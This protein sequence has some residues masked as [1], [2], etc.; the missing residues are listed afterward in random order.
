[1]EMFFIILFL[2]VI[3]I[4]LVWRFFVFHKPRN[5]DSLFPDKLTPIA[6][7]GG[8]SIAP[9][10]TMAAFR[11]SAGLGVSFELDTMFSKDGELVVIHDETL[12]RTTDGFGRVSDMTA[13]E[14]AALDAG[15]H[16]SERYRS[17]GVSKLSDVLS[18]FGGKRAIIIEVKCKEGFC[19]PKRLAKALVALLGEKGMEDNVLIAS[20]NSLLL[21]EVRKLNPSIMRGQIY[22][23]FKRDDLESY[24]RFLSKNLLLNR[25]SK[26][27]ALM[28]KH[29][30]VDEGY[31][32]RMHGRGYK[33]FPWTVDD[34]DE[35][36]RLIALGVDGIITNDP[37]ALNE[38]LS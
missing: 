13:A 23:D 35:M 12:E 8:S 30:L 14:L 29:V 22:S 17:E 20:F 25:F 16:F 2:I 26:P 4:L 6:H 32:E 28:V 19:K 15:S 1:M 24:K 34:P 38:A 7:R 10:N 33:I 5:T 21:Y 3:V 27:D 37:V 31:V 36:K 11:L 18:D 9:E